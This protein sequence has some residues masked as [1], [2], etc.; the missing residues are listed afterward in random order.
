MKCPVVRLES[1]SRTVGRDVQLFMF[2]QSLVLDL[3]FDAH[4]IGKLEPDMLVVRAGHGLE[5]S[6]ARKMVM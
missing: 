3:R 2:S 1:C 6:V 4:V 5:V